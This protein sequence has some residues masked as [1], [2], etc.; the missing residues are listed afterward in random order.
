M[1]MAAIPFFVCK[2][3]HV[4]R[5]RLLGNIAKREYNGL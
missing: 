3:E 1:L 4:E 5:G 2:K